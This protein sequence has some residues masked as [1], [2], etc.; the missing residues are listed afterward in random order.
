MRLDT[1][2]CGRWAV[3]GLSTAFL[4]GLLGGCDPGLADQKGTLRAGIVSAN[5]VRVPGCS[6]EAAEHHKEVLRAAEVRR[7]RHLEALWRIH[8]DLRWDDPEQ[9]A[10]LE[11]AS[12]TTS[13]MIDE[14][15][16]VVSD[17]R[18]LL[19]ELGCPDER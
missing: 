1:R 17:E 7:G 6:S 3:L 16:T 13:A 19:A 15:E 18:A 4:T 14:Q 8:G 9:L 10:G 5:V 12:A 2:I 11:Y